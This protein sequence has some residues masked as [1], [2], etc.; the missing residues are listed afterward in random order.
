VGL[1][2]CVPR[3]NEVV[4][5]IGTNELVAGASPGAVAE[6]IGQIVDAIQ[7]TSPRTRILLL[8][9]LPRGF[10]T[11]PVRAD[12]AAANAGTGKQHANQVSAAA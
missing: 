9:I 3:A 8:G 5:M 12:I 1:P 11:D 10:P 2:G 6:A 7:A 4:L